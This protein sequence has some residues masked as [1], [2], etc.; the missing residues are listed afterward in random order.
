MLSDSDIFSVAILIQQINYFLSNGSR[1]QLKF[2]KKLLRFI[3]CL[4]SRARQ[5][6]CIKQS[7]IL[8][9][10][11]SVAFQRNLQITHKKKFDCLLLFFFY[12]FWTP[13]FRW[14]GSYETASSRRAI[15]QCVSGSLC[16]YVV[17]QLSV[18]FQNGS[19][20]FSEVNMKLEGLKIQKL[21]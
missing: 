17:G 18:F 4:Q 9:I 20:D 15:G 21:T 2:L 11:S 19:E 12:Y 13:V 5:L 14:R 16:Q 6:L 10:F 7:R 1:N 8:Y 3:Y